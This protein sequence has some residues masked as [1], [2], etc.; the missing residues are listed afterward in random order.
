MSKAPAPY[1]LE[2]KTVLSSIDRQQLDFYEKLTEEE[3]KAYSPFV[4]MRYMSSLANRDPN[5]MFAILA[6]NDLVNVGFKDLNKHPELQHKLLCCAG[7]SGKQYRPWIPVP[8]GKRG[9][10]NTVQKFLSETYPQCNST[11][12]DLI[13]ATVT[14]DQLDQLAYANNVKDKDIK[15]MLKVLADR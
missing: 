10:Q 8:R 6:T 15:E 9:G 5:Q 11:E 13:Y 12:L 7:I 14:P 3:K 4:I 2:M 1:K